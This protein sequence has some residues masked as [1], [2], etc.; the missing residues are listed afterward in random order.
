MKQKRK[1]IWLL[2]MLWVFAGAITVS[3]EEFTISQTKMTMNTGDTIDLDM[4]GT[5]EVAKWFSWNVNT[6]KVN[7]EGEVTAVRTGKTTIGA[8]IG[9][10]TSKCAVT[11][12]EPSIKLNKST[13][14]IYVGGTSV[15]TVQL[16]ATVKGASKEIQW[17]SS[18][19]RVAAVDA[20]GKVTSVSNG[21]VKITARANGKTASCIVEV[22]KSKV[23]LNIN[24]MQLSIKGNGSNMKLTASVTGSDKKVTWST[25]NK[26]VA[27]V[28]DGKVTGKGNFIAVKNET[29]LICLCMKEV[30]GRVNIYNRY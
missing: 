16:K 22:K 2:M 26:N 10:V 27:A 1:I 5:G 15:N 18:N 6:A 23:S 13:A 9:N 20:N 12:V 11:V 7:Q 25:S 17:K 29:F 28:K 8:R 21:K 3:A 19:P 14:V 4:I 30:K 24:Q